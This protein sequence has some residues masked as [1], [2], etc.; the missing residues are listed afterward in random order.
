MATVH[1]LNNTRRTATQLRDG[2]N[3]AARLVARAINLH[4]AGRGL[5]EKSLHARLQRLMQN[6][7]RAKSNSQIDADLTN[8]KTVDRHCG[9]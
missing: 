2:S 4:T 6:P 5:T 1:D 7:A 8:Q 3:N 9:D